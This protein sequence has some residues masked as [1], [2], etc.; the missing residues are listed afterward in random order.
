MKLNVNGSMCEKVNRV[1]VN[2]KEVAYCFAFDTEAG[3]ADSHVMSPELFEHR[4]M[5]ELSENGIILRASV[6]TG[7]VMRQHGKV[8]VEWKPKT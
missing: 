5:G 7:M 6:G 2:D 8:D 1:F 3:W 4:K